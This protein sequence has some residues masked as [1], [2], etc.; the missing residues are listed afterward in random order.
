MS[1][2][3]MPVTV[4]LDPKLWWQLAKIAETHHM[5]SGEVL[6]ELA[7]KLV[8]RP[9]THSRA[10]RRTAGAPHG[11][12][13]TVRP[14]YARAE[15]ERQVIE[16]YAL[17]KSDA[18][19]AAVIGCSA[20]T[21]RQRRVGLGLPPIAVRGRRGQYTKAAVGREGINEMEHVA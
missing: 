12:S 4:K 10:R 17:R 5:T 1:T 20:E 7:Q 15:L 2:E 21:V 8:S 18:Q 13:G 14:T 9:P 3:T 6:A 16:Q 11:T 19:I